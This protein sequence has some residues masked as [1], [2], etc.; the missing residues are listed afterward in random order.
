[1]TTSR[2]TLND[3]HTIP[4]L[5]FGV[6]QVPPA[7][8]ERV[9]ADALE[10][11]YRHIDTAQMYQNESGVGR[12]VA[13]SG[14]PR[15]EVFLTTKVN[16]NAHRPADAAASIER[17]LT[18]LGTDYV[19]LLL[20]HWPL[21]TQYGGDF[22]STWEALIAA[23]DAGHVRSIGVSNFQAA[24]LQAL[25]ST[26]VTPAVNQIEVH[27]RFANNDVRAANAAQG[28]VTEVWS[29]LGQGTIL[30]DPAI[31]SIAD[32]LGRTPA[33]VIIR[34]HLQ[35]GDVVFPKTV[36]A[37]RMQENA[38]VFG[39]ELSPEDLR[40]IDALEKG[41]AGRIGPNPDVFDWIP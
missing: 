33:Q 13:A 24:H 14:L 4:Q 32:R 38:D 11:G 22:V 17:S 10:V 41:E 28:T 35:R 31:T 5:G 36:T 40:A 20:I 21:P 19:D 25:H 1:M 23:R 29:P 3:G 27:P 34:W 30:A 39:F 6:W 16:N 26:G 37:T 18:E 12:A 8:A 15:A 7:E 9:V 2:I